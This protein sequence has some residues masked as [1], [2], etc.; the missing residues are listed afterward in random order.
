MFARGSAMRLAQKARVAANA[1]REDQ[2]STY[3]EVAALLAVAGP[4]AGELADEPCSLGIPAA[5]DLERAHGQA[6]A[7]AER[8]SSGSLAWRAKRNAA[9]VRC[10]RARDGGHRWPSL[11]RQGWCQQ[12]NEHPPRAVVCWR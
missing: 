11:G 12:P 10:S 5:S 1:M 6:G 3:A 8:Q 2:R 9:P 4:P 7:R